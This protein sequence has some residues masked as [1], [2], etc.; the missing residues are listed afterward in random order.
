MKTG[1]GKTIRRLKIII[2]G[3]VQG[4]G[5]RPFVFRLANFMGLNGWVIN[6]SQG[7]IIEVEGAPE[8]LNTFLLKV[9][10]EKPSLAS[11]ASLEFS[12]LDPSGFTSFEVRKSDS[13]GEKTAFILPDISTCPDCLADIFDP[14]NRR[15]QYPFTNCTNCGPRFSI[16]QKLPYDRPNTTMVEFEMCDKCQEEYTDPGNRRFHAQPNACPDCGPHIQFWDNSGKVMASR[17]EAILKTA[18]AIKDGFIVAVKGIGGFHLM[19]DAGNEE[20]VKRLRE[21]KHR[22][23]KPLAMM[24]PSL[25][26]IE[27]VCHVDALEKRLLTSP[28]DPIVLLR[29]RQNIT[30]EKFIIATSVSPQNPYFGI[31]L[32][33][34]PLHHLLMTEL[35]I[36]IVATSGNISEEPICIDEHEAVERLGNISD[37]FLVHNRPIAR[38]VDDSI[39]CVRMSRQQILRRA[40]GFAPLPIEIDIDIKI[41]MNNTDDPASHCIAVGAHLKNTIAL[42]VKNNVFVSQHIGDLETPK[43]LDAFKKVIADFQNLYDAPATSIAADMHPGYLSSQFARDM[44]LPVVEVQHHYAHILSCMAENHLSPPLL[45]I[46]FDGTGYGPDGTIWG[47]EFLKITADGFKRAAHWRT[48]PL[49]GGKKAIKE[50]RRS[51]I[52]MLYEIFGDKLFSDFSFK[53]VT[54]FSKQDLQILSTILNKQINTHITSSLGRLFDAIAAIIDLQQL[55]QFEG[56]AAMALEFLAEE[57]CTDAVYPLDLITDSDSSDTPAIVDWEPMIKAIL[58]DITDQKPV[59]KISATFH[60]TLAEASVKVAKHVGEKK[61]VLSG[62]CFQNKYLTEQTVKRLTVEGFAVYWHQRIPP[63]DGGI[64]LGQVVA[65]GLVLKNR[66]K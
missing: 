9:E 3:A 55:N 40:R 60:N 45:G 56:Q 8:F 19:A 59:A 34:T 26:D 54:A 43:A 28:E 66:D 33:Y 1:K 64:S 2:Q 44:E 35:G 38:H 62:G 63:N 5:F 27:T 36:P 53:P 42:T 6:S 41:G 15:Y 14:D 39:V 51:A 10:K 49:P 37:F 13:K 31:M 22:P 20:A 29:A 4:V 24:F 58:N 61:I 25:Q 30:S 7:V 50:P 17:H 16:I 57:V 65:A 12:W 18:E 48:F 21:K 52:G 46:A 32:P 23:H 11:I 47:G